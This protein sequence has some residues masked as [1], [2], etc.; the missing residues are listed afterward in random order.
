MNNVKN[1]RIDTFEIFKSKFN[2]NEKKEYVDSINASLNFEANTFLQALLTKEDKC[3]SL[4]IELRLPYLD[5]LAD[6]TKSSNK[7]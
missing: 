1:E 4:S 7:V 5:N 6:F 2:H 3:R